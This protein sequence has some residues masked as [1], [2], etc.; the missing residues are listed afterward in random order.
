MEAAIVIRYGRPTGREKLG[1]EAF[2][3]ALGFFGTKAGDGAC[4]AP[5]TYMSS[6]GGG[7]LVVAG[8][9]D[10]L[11]QIVAGDDFIRMY[12]KA[13]FAVADLTYEIMATGDDAVTQMGLWAEV[14]S[15]LGLM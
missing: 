2:Q 14:G 5:V 15:E 6:T 1:F 3:D 9:R 13:G 11:A 12:L 4:R 10:A 8:D 7:M